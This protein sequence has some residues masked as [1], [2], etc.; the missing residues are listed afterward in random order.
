MAR[1]RPVP[2]PGG[3]SV[4]KSAFS[5][6]REALL[7][8]GLAPVLILGA[9]AAYYLTR[10][11]TLTIA[12]APNGGTEPALLRAYADELARRGVGIR[13]KVIPFDGVRESA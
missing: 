5:R 9:A 10:P 13:L 1:T 4:G 3:V 6:S 7:L 11:T 2:R 12:V 8:L